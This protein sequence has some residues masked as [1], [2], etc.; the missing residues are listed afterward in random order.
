MKFYQSDVHFRTRMPAS[1]NLDVTFKV[2]KNTD[3]RVI[4]KEKIIKDHNSRKTFTEQME[5]FPVINFR[6]YNPKDEFLFWS[7]TF[8]RGVSG[9]EAIISVVVTV[10]LCLFCLVVLGL[11]LK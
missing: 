2:L 8:G 5:Q 10:S 9:E 7:E 3:S 1:T 4:N 11:L 6:P